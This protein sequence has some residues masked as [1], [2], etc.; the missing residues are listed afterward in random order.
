MRS[1]MKTSQLILKVII[2]YSSPLPR[3]SALIGG[4]LKAY[5]R[6]QV[7]S[8]ILLLLSAT[9]ETMR[10]RG[11]LS[12]LVGLRPLSRS[13]RGKVSSHLLFWSKYDK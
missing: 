13:L 11:R 3:H 10:R 8:S 12:C 9:T 7:L 1:I 6:I 2:P 4:G 5:N